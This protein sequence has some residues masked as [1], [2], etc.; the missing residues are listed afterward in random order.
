M[1]YF[2]KM[3]ESAGLV[4]GMASSLDVDL[5]ERLAS[6]PETGARSYAEMVRRCSNCTQQSA[7]AQLQEAN[8]MLDDA[9]EYCT[10]RDLLHR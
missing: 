4:S 5:T 10:N 9:P 6:S 2:S 3:S 8:P 1:T 7:C